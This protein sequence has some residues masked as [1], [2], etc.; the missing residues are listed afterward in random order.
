MHYPLLLY[1]EHEPSS[2]EIH[3]LHTTLSYQHQHFNLKLRQAIDLNSFFLREPQ[4][5]WLFEITER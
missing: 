1:T 3:D 5:L 2:D 4:A